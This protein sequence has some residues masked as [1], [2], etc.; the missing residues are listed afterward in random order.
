MIKEK[1]GYFH[2]KEKMSKICHF[3]SEEEEAQFWAIHDFAD[4][5]VDSEEV[6]MEISSIKITKCSTY[7]F[8]Q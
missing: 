4:F 1:K 8:D 6:N 2:E 7:R 3:K 5:M